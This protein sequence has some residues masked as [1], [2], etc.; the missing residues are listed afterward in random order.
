MK[1]IL[2]KLKSVVQSFE[3][4]H[5]PILLCALFLRKESFEKWDIV[6]SAPWL[7]SSEEKSYEIIISKVRSIL[8]P[9]EV[10]RISRI[11]ILDD[12]DPVVAFFQDSCLLE[13]EEFKES[14]K[15]FSVDP[16]SL[17]FGFVI[18]KAYMIR[19][20]RASAP[21]KGHQMTN[22]QELSY[23]IACK[24]HVCW[25]QDGIAYYGAFFSAIVIVD[26][27]SFCTTVDLA[28]SKE[29][30]II[31]TSLK[32]ETQ[33][34]SLA[35]RQGAIL[36]KK[37]NECGITLSPSS[38][39]NLDPKQTILLTSPNGSSLMDIASRFEKPVFAGCFRNSKALSEFL[40]LREF[41]PVLFVAAGERF[42][43]AML[44]PSLED[45]WGVGSI[46]ANLNGDKTIE[47]E[48]A[49]QSFNSIASNLTSNLMACES[50]Q[51]LIVHG[52]E[53]DVELAAEFNASNVIS[54]LS[55]RNGSL[56]LTSE[57]HVKD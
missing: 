51:E 33:L 42:S 40:N 32:D 18:I 24:H 54:V 20:H 53:Q 39:R 21:F 56:Y 31:P 52:Y 30:S 14:P 9:S 25:G 17:K 35:E 4:E 29:C 36:A 37:R 13:G 8:T 22:I 2:N 49:I 28:L 10:V 19:C 15:D 26:V 55:R 45:Y 50:G 16:F 27:L 12:N 38:M 7:N 43:N 34:L 41:F 11:I 1:E 57:M 44:K 46:L 3:G 48:D 47:A 6:V 5:A 23:P